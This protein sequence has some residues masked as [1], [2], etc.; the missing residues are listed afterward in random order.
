ML[1][2]LKNKFNKL[3]GNKAFYKT[4]IA[5]ALPIMLQQ[6]ITSF[7]SILDNLMVGQLDTISFEAVSINNKYIAQK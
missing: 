2:K 5:I 3:I 1:L 7:V 6:G 4:T